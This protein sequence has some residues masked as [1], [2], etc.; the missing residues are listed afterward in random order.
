MELVR[1]DHHDEVAEGDQEHKDGVEIPDDGPLA[2]TIEAVYVVF[3]GGRVR[4]RT[5]F[6]EF[7]QVLR[8]LFWFRP[9]GA[10]EEEAIIVLIDVVLA[11]VDIGI[12]VAII[13]LNLCD[14]GH[15]FSP[16]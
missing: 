1:T 9:V 10:R 11:S 3:Q 16:E 2:T 5:S 15:A 6:Q 8:C 4:A 13:V 7:L 14:I 12:H